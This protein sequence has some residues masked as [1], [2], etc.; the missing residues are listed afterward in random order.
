MI[1]NKRA[2]K[3]GAMEGGKPSTIP[4]APGA[5]GT[6]LAQPSRLPM[7]FNLKVGRSRLPDTRDKLGLGAATSQPEAPRQDEV[8]IG[9]NSLDPAPNGVG[10]GKTAMAGPKAG[11]ADEGHVTSAEK[12][13]GVQFHR[14][15]RP[16]LSERTI[17]TLSQI[18]PSPSPRRRKSGIY[19]AD[20]TGGSSARPPSSLTESRPHTS[21]GQRR[22]PSTPR[23]SSPTKRQEESMTSS[24]SRPTPTRRSVSS[25]MPKSLPRVSTGF[26]GTND[27]TPSKVPL[28]PKL[29]PNDPGKSSNHGVS[30]PPLSLQGAARNYERGPSVLREDDT[31]QEPGRQ[32]IMKP[33]LG[34]HTYAAKSTRQRIPLDD[35]FS[36]QSSGAPNHQNDRVPPR[37]Q[38]IPSKAGSKAKEPPCPTGP[39]KA[40]PTKGHPPPSLKNLHESKTVSSVESSV[41]K[42]YS[43]KSSAALRETIAKAKAAR[44][45]AGKLGDHQDLV[46]RKNL[47]VSVIGSGDLSG[48]FS[49]ENVLRKRMNIAR[50]SGRLN[51][52]ALGLAEF[53]QCVKDMYNIENVD[54]NNGEWYE[55]VD[56]VRLMAADNEFEFLPDWTFPDI[57]L[58]ITDLE[59]GNIFGGLQSIDLHGNRL[60]EL[61]CGLRRLTRLTSIDLSR[62][63]LVNSCFDVLSQV[64][65]L[66]ELKLAKNSIQG[67]L[68]GS[69]GRLI[70]LENLDLQDN[71]LTDLGLALK[72]LTK[73]RKLAV[74][75]NR[76]LMIPFQ[77]L[78]S[79]PLVEINAARNQLAGVLMPEGI[80]DLAA[81]R[82]LDLSNNALTALSQSETLSL[83]SLQDLNVTDNRLLTIPN[84]SNWKNLITLC[85]GGNKLTSIPDG[86]TFLPKL[87]TLDLSRNSIKLLDTRLGTMESLVSLQVGNNPLLD[88]RYLTMHTDDLKQE[89]RDRFLPPPKLD[90]HGEETV[91]NSEVSL[92]AAGS[93]ARQIT[94]HTK[95]GGILDRSSTN[96][97]A[98]EASH[99]EPILQTTE[100]KSLIFHHNS[101]SLIPS[102]LSLC[103]NTITAVDLSHN[104]LA[105]E[106]Y[107]PFPLSLPNLKS[108][109]LSSNTISDLSALTTAL[110]APLLSL[111][112]VSYNRLHS[113]PAVRT[114]YPSLTTL[115]ASN[116]S[117]SVLE[118]DTAKGLNVLDVSE[119]A[120]E[121][122]E[123]RLGLL[124]AQGLRTLVVGGN[125]FRVPRREILEKGTDAVL[126]WLRGRIPAADLE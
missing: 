39:T 102:A 78:A 53:P 54:V 45:L 1:W 55:S 35:I 82:T 42:S 118:V 59:E 7:N 116:N 97:H 103:Q 46:N 66:Q 65:S 99:L 114:R 6:R 43:P 88:R 38:A 110:D 27:L 122:L 22:I 19:P 72:D 84:V 4:R 100:I 11:A 106:T 52:A 56:L 41:N 21:L 51:I 101:L 115:L 126:A 2:Q 69:L 107:A 57:P 16:S 14:R 32:K 112:N 95:P 5:S 12:P 104:S 24:Y 76:L 108:L 18:P 125:R 90:N 124:A 98:L 105:N 36:R 70:N 120:I 96:L 68:D 123:P 64:T 33:K 15:P 61:P 62:N 71:A 85:A 63:R 93:A 17:E 113:L 20:M 13:Q 121:R 75:G 86:L 34:A 40:A 58:D 48:E 67:A 30:R 73:L 77:L 94:W 109:N 37:I 79:L 60:K 89:L 9:D 49:D 81:L 50:T 8:G 87:K 29:P 44:R 83:V 117:I 74:A 26:H 28:V 92:D 47:P 111:L 80:N 31:G 91:P 25:F 3:A 10:E 119:N 23:R